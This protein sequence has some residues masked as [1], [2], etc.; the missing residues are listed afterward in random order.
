V[1]TLV[2][3]GGGFLGRAGVEALLAEGHAVTS[4]GRTSHAELE[5]LGARALRVDLADAAAVER[6]VQGHEVVFHVAALTGVWGRRRDFERA[7]VLGTRN[8]LAACRAG[9]VRALVHTSSPAVCFDG[10]DHVRASN[11]LPRARRF[12][13]D[14]ARTK[15]RAEELVLGANDE[16]LATC[17]LRPHLV[18]G[19]RDPHLVPRLVARA[20]TGRLLV[21]GDGANEVSVT[22]VENAAAAHVDAA[23]ALGPGAPHAG[24]A[25]FLGQEEPV[26]LWSWVSELLAALGLPPPRRRVPLAL[27]YAAG[28]ACEALWR[29][30][31]LP[32][33]P[34]LTRFV[35]RQ[36]ATSHS[37][38]LG[39]ARRDFGY[40]ERVPL[41]EA[42]RRLVAWIRGGGGGG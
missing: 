14:Y 11:D 22:Y 3:G 4:I 38:D 16:S 5:E 23:R 40:R 12:L 10:R 29:M 6:A 15:A 30:V 7:N 25:Y 21:V 28:G 18:F 24:R 35:A 8:V 36:L 32:G 34:P 9:G 13:C 31:P 42:T 41:A 26:E 19:P 27:A 39:P 37:Y 20:R 17:A 2:T 1:R 33:E